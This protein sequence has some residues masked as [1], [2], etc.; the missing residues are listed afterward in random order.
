MTELSHG[1]EA[2]LLH[3]ERVMIKAPWS[4]VYVPNQFVLV[5]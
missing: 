4:L 5:A 2:W 3:K 1:G